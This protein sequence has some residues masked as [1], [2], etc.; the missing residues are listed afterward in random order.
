MGSAAVVIKATEAFQLNN[1][2]FLQRVKTP[3]FSEFNNS[4]QIF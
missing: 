3:V 1:F 4:F 2:F